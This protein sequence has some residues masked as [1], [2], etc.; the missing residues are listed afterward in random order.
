MA[1]G[2]VYDTG[3]MEWIPAQQAVLNSSSVTIGG[4]LTANQGTASTT[5]WSVSGSVLVSNAVM[6][7]SI[8][9]G[10]VNASSNNTVVTPTAGKKLRVHY[11]SYNPAEAVE[12]AFRLGSTGTRFL[13]N[14]LVAGGSIV[15]KDFGDFRYLEG[16][17][18]DPLILNLSSGVITIWNAFYTEV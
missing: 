14:N 12:A 4:T 8:A 17:V 15:A 6:A 18:N 7:L 3:T 10:S 2:K 16:A 5:A 9:S 1:Y 11:V 13:R